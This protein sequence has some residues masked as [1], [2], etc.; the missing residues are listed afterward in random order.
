MVVIAI[1]SLPPTVLSQLHEFYFFIFL[2]FRSILDQILSY[3]A[4]FYF[5]SYYFI[6]V[7]YLFLVPVEGSDSITEK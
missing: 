3:A 4:L 2:L 6:V 1:K 7:G 5:Y